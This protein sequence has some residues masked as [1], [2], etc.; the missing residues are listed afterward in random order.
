MSDDDEWRE[1]LWLQSDVTFR[2]TFVLIVKASPGNS[3]YQGFL[4]QFSQGPAAPH[5]LITWLITCLW[6]HMSKYSS[7]SSTNALHL[8]YLNSDLLLSCW[9]GPGSELSFSALTL[10]NSENKTCWSE[11]EEVEEEDCPVLPFLTEIELKLLRIA[12]VCVYFIIRVTYI[13]IT[14]TLIRLVLD[15]VLASTCSNSLKEKESLAG[16]YHSNRSADSE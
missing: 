8:I 10:T 16:F 12:G 13:T 1:I 11:L 7:T 6:D 14:L 3:G 9:Y 15:G 5:K 2:R 4:T